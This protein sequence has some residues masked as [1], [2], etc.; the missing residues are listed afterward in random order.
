[1]MVKY[2]SLDDVKADINRLLV[3]AEARSQQLP[4]E[5]RVFR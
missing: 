5:I 4:T 1:M 2:L 3:I